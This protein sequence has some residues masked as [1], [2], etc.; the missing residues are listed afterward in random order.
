M[1]FCSSSLSSNRELCQVGKITK[2]VYY[3]AGTMVIRNR[4][5]FKKEFIQFFKNPLFCNNSGSVIFIPLVIPDQL[6][7]PV[8]LE[9]KSRLSHVRHNSNPILNNWSS[10]VSPKC[11]GLS[12]ADNLFLIFRILMCIS[13]KEPSFWFLFSFVW[14]AFSLPP[15]FLQVRWCAITHCKILCSVCCCH[16]AKGFLSKCSGESV[17]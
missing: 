10:S 5:D 17:L 9:I 2:F 7:F 16:W 6:P 15:L 4:Q 13:S 8:I 1:V 12:N 11:F 3:W 14:S